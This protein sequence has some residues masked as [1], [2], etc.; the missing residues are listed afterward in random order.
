MRKGQRKYTL[1]DILPKFTLN[2]LWKEQAESYVQE[3]VAELDRHLEDLEELIGRKL[4]SK[5]EYDILTIVD[6]HSI[7]DDDGYIVEF[8][9]FDYAWKIYQTKH[10]V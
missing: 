1:A 5:E 2:D 7:K 8:L 10:K 9:P 4:T 6:E 3:N